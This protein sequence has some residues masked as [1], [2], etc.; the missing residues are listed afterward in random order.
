[1]SSFFITVIPYCHSLRG[2]DGLESCH[3]DCLSF[4]R[5]IIL[6]V[7]KNPEVMD[8]QHCNWIL[9]YA[10]NDGF[11]GLS[12]LGAQ[13]RGNLALCFVCFAKIKTLRS[14]WRV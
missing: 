14:Q 12:L 6:S 5:F 7:A 8:F 10:Q 13:R 9:R 4:Q 11:Y 3:C 2:S 1:M